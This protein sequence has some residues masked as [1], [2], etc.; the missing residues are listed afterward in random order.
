MR[1]ELIDYLLRHEQKS[2]A[3]AELLVLSA[4]LPDEV[5]SQRQ[6]GRL[7]LDAGDP[8]RA[9]DHFL[10]ALRL[11]PTDQAAREGAAE[12]A[13]TAG[14]YLRARTY[15][16]ALNA[17]SPRLAEMEVIAEIILTR[18]PLAPRLRFT[19]RRRRLAAGLQQA[20]ER[21][22]GCPGVD[23]GLRQEL[24][25]LGQSLTASR[26][27]DDTDLIEQGVE[28]IGRIELAAEQL[29]GSGGAIDRGWRAIAERHGDSQ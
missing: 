27:S 29:C 22:V 12:A 19:E 15:L 21:L 24:A 16:R 17:P 2:R 6:I 28:L 14:D 5:L 9:L 10:R 11:A 23:D 7:F 18:D 26:G 25:G 20:Q 8:R 3:L 13:F 4:N 1:I